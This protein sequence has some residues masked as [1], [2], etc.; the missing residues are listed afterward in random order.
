M[1]PTFLG[2]AVAILAVACLTFVG[3]PA[4][5]ASGAK[6]VGDVR[7]KAM[8]VRIDKPN[9]N[10]GWAE[11]SKQTRVVLKSR[12]GERTRGDLNDLARGAKVLRKRGTNGE[13]RRV[14]LA[15]S[16]TGNADCSFDSSS[17]DGDDVSNDE[18]FDCSSDYDDG[19][20]DTSEDCSYD[21]SSDGPASDWSMDT[22]WDCSFSESDDR[23]DS[24][25]DWDCS[26]SASAGG[27]ED[28][29]GGDVDADL[30]F[31][32]SWSGAGTGSALWDCRFL[33]GVL[34]FKCVSPQLGQE[35]TYTID[36][37]SMQFVGG[38][39]F[40][41]DLITKKPG[42]RGL[43][44]SGS[45]V[46]GYDCDYDGGSESGNCGVDW[47]FDESRGTEDGDVS[48]SLSY[49]CSWDA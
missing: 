12:D 5:A 43:S 48:G 24:D 28:A 49:D 13:L 10:R 21:A 7:A 36:T 11:V 23:A 32:C 3:Q 38:M 18:S 34:G 29:D 22:S 33:P 41:K 20:V 15:A 1:S 9:G 14:V 40:S 25:I 27:Y 45:E 8:K 2:R 46:D 47:S 26:Y 37:E 19:V 44:C 31:D 35:F 30:D 17:D 6:H 42:D 39:D 4:V 16:P